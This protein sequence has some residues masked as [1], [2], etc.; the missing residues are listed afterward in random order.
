GPTFP[1]AEGGCLPARGGDRPGGPGGRRSDPR[2]WRGWDDRDGGPDTARASGGAGRPAGRNAEP[3]REV[4]GPERPRGVPGD[5]YG[6]RNTADRYR[7]GERAGFPEHQLRG[8][9]RGARGTA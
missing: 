8:H 6:R 5:R 7:T 3:L 4:A 2:G 1:A 9:L